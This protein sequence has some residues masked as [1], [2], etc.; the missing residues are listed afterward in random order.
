MLTEL[1]PKTVAEA[2]YNGEVE[3]ELRRI[4]CTEY[5]FRNDSDR[6]LCMEMIKFNGKTFIHTFL[7]IALKSAN[8]GVKLLIR[9][10]FNLPSVYYIVHV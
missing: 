5:V 3:N 9:Y 10:K 2:F 7:V 1:T 6:E 4:G 8:S